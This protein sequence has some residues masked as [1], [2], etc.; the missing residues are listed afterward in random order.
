MSYA[1]RHRPPP[2]PRCRPERRSY[3]RHRRL[4]MHLRRHAPPP[5]CARHCARARPLQRAARMPIGWV[6]TPTRSPTGRARGA[7]LL[8]GATFHSQRAPSSSIVILSCSSWPGSRTAPRAMPSAPRPR[9]GG[10]RRSPSRG[11]AGRARTS[12]AWTSAH[13]GLI[14]EP[15][16]L[17][18]LQL[19][20]RGSTGQCGCILHVPSDWTARETKSANSAKLAS[21]VQFLRDK[22]APRLVA[23][24]RCM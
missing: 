23:R 3:V 13:R 6:T 20:V 18:S 1:N 5:H 9:A 16:G 19:L 10:T 11:R 8:W 22:A 12:R 7:A 15:D 4:P 2:P 24:A 21:F 17:V 14:T